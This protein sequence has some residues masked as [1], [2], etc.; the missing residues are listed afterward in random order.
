MFPILTENKG[1]NEELRNVSEDWNSQSKSENSPKIRR[2]VIELEPVAGHKSSP[3]NRK[4]GRR[5]RHTD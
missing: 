3:E 1:Y 5:P 2:G 4:K